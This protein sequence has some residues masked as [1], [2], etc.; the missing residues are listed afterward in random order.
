MGMGQIFLLRNLEKLNG[1][2]SEN[3]WSLIGQCFCFV[4]FCFC[5]FVL[6]NVGVSSRTSERRN[7]LDGA[8]FAEA[9]VVCD[10]AESP[11]GEET[12]IRF[13]FILIVL[14]TLRAR[15]ELEF[16]ILSEG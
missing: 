9:C 2:T 11:P 3:W 5:V 15:G 7:S 14:L 6:E 13:E 16:V 12:I 1:K 4:S 10:T 8:I